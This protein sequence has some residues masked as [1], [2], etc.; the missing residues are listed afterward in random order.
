MSSAGSGSDAEMEGEDEL[1][2]SSAQ[3]ED[4]DDSYDSR[5]KK[6]RKTN[7]T[8]SKEVKETAEDILGKHRGV[9][10]LARPATAD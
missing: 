8:K 2:H 7:G 10:C 6:R 5:K 3:S 4:S 9:S 1:D